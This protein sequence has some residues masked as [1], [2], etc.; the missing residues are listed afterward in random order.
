MDQTSNIKPRENKKMVTIELD[1]NNLQHRCILKALRNK[2][3]MFTVIGSDPTAADTV[4]YWLTKNH[5]LPDEKKNTTVST[6]LAIREYE[7]KKV[8]D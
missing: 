4:A 3:P 2:M 8:A 1:E 7:P 5:Q 6:I